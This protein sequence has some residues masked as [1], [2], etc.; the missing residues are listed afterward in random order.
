MDG[1]AG[2]KPRVHT[3]VPTLRKASKKE[4][5]VE[6]NELIEQVQKLVEEGTSVKAACKAIGVEPKEYRRAIKASCEDDE[7]KMDVSPFPVQ[8]SKPNKYESV[9]LSPAVDKT[10]QEGFAIKGSPAQIAEFLRHLSKEFSK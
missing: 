9:E 4:K 1:L 6:M 3:R 2:E 10:T 5:G 8:W 7:V